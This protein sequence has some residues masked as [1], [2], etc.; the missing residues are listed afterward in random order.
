M[1]RG[2]RLAFNPLGF[3]VD[4]REA[5]FD[6]FRPERHQPQRIKSELRSPALA[7]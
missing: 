5:D 7:S 6:V 2:T 3:G 1:L 4:V